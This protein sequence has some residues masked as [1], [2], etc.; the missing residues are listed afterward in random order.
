MLHGERMKDGLVQFLCLFPECGIKGP[1]G[2]QLRHVMVKLLHAQR[3]H[4]SLIQGRE[5]VRH[6]SYASSPPRQGLAIVLQS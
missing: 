6:L 3:T 4:I 1:E 2:E 5:T